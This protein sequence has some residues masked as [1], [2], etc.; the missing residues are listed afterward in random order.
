MKYKEYIS[1]ILQNQEVNTY[2]LSAGIM[3][4][5]WAN[6]GWAHFV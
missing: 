1:L 5:R 2:A 4:K 6:G 3:R